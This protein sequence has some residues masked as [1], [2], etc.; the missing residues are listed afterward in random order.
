[1][2]ELI[3]FVLG[4][5]QREKVIQVLEARG[6]MTSRKMAKLG[7]LSESS[8]ERVLKE[9]EE[10]GLVKDENDNWSLT[11]MGAQVQNGMKRRM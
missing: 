5:K 8:V 4:N 3:G 6:S 1:M 9:I 7:R 2:D 11:E 10:K